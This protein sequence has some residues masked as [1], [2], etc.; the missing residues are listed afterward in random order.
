MTESKRGD[1]SGRT[2][3]RS[4]LEQLGVHCLGR[5]LHVTHDRPSDET[6]LDGGLKETSI[7]GTEE[8]REREG[9]GGELALSG[10]VSF[11]LV[12]RRP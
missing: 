5:Q 3:P 10:D 4:I 2:S 1:S 6:V 9:E 11:V 12:L 8:R 7:D